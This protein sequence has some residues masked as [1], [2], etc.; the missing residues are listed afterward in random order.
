GVEAG[1]RLGYEV[2]VG[3][4]E[5][6]V[7]LEGVGV[8]DDHE[9]DRLLADGVPEHESGPD[10]TPD[11]LTAHVDDDLSP[12]LVRLQCE[13]LGAGQAGALLAR[14]AA[15]FRPAPRGSKMAAFRLMR[16]TTWVRGSSRP[17]SGA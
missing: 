11:R 6:V 10:Q 4:E 12:A 5:E 9:Q 1:R 13:L 8:G 7:G 17:T 15:L 3:G 16:E 14:P 2:E